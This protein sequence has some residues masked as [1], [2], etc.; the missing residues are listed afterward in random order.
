MTL[1]FVFLNI[2]FVPYDLRTESKTSS[3]KVAQLTQVLAEHV[4]FCAHDSCDIIII[5]RLIL[6][7][8]YISPKKAVFKEV[9]ERN[10]I[11]CKLA[12]TFVKA[13]R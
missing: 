11:C 8:R 4:M 7:E 3:P 5:R 13:K 2:Y 10:L 12:N 1:I 6:K 9:K